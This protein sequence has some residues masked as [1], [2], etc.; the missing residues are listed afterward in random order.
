MYE[1]IDKIT[2]YGFFLLCG[3][4]LTMVGYIVYVVNVIYKQEP[5]KQVEQKTS[6]RNL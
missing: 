2:V 3:M 4:I 1:S 5:G 6:W